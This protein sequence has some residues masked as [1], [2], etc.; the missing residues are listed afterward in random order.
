[1]EWTSVKDKLP[2]RYEL[3]LTYSFDG[4]V[5]VA[6][7]SKHLNYGDVIVWHGEDS[8]IVNVTH[9]IPLPKPPKAAQD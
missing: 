1:M 3:V 5:G 8:E 2:E 4:Q 7:W 6:S 9:W